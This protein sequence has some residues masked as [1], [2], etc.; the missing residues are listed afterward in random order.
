MPGRSVAAPAS[1]L[2]TFLWAGLVWAQ[3]PDPAAG[4]APASSTPPAEEQAAS[5]THVGL[6]YKIGNG[7][8]F[9][10]G[11]LIIS[12]LPHVVLDLQASS[13]SAGTS[14]G[15]ATGWGIAPALQVD[16]REPGRSTPYLSLGYVYATLSI[17]NVTASGSGVSLNAGY[18]WKWPFGMGILVG[19]GICHFGNLK[20]TGGTTTISRDAQFIPVLEAGI[21]FMFL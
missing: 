9:L 10:G 18:E 3:A 4:P 13:F 11:D 17:D 5:A 19:G 7:L 2:V 6:G 14:S 21:R 20:A 8:G 1:A 16:I 12:P 15:T